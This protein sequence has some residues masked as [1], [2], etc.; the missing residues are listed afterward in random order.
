MVLHTFLENKARTAASVPRSTQP[1]L[2]ARNALSRTAYHASME[3]IAPNA[4][5]IFTYPTARHS[6]ASHVSNAPIKTANRVSIIPVPVQNVFPG[7]LISLRKCNA[8]RPQFQTANW[9][10]TDFVG[11]AV[12]GS[13]SQAAISNAIK[14]AP[15]KTVKH[16]RNRNVP[17][18]LLDTILSRAMMGLNR[19]RKIPVTFKTATCV[20]WKAFASTVL[21]TTL[22][23][24]SILAK[25]TAVWMVVLLVIKTSPNARSAKREKALTSGHVNARIIAL[26]TVSSTDSWFK[27]DLTATNAFKI[28]RSTQT[29]QNASKSVAL[30][31]VLNAILKIWQN[32][33]N[34]I[35]D[36]FWRKSTASHLVKN[37]LAK[38]E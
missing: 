38:L 17:S 27:M 18:V 3:H 37:I 26:K 23:P 16:A 31:T 7:T 2:K 33:K 6:W 28:M 30:R 15:W 29:I 35:L 25:R 24:I 20:T 22:W 14:T 12:Q 8:L 19:A 13:S 5:Q 11:S 34:V 4:H 1:A 10:A 32:A 9:W 21:N 36:L